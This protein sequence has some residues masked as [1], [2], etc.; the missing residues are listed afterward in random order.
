MA[1]FHADEG[2]DLAFAM[3]PLDVGGGE[4]EFKGIRVFLHH[5]M[6]DINLLE[7][8]LDRFGTV[9]SGWDVHGPE[10][11]AEAT[12]AKAR[13]IGDHRVLQ[14]AR[15]LAKIDGGEVVAAFAILPGDVVV[16]VYEWDFFEDLADVGEVFVIGRMRGVASDN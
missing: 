12:F 15:V 11:A 1:A 7:D 13:D 3:D 2:S 4:S 6:H 5:V 10:L 14:L 8:S 9:Q 16:A